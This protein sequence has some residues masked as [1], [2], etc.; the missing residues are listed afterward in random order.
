MPVS[1]GKHNTGYLNGQ[2]YDKSYIM[3]QD[4]MNGGKLSFVMGSAPN[5]NWASSPAS[6]P[7]SLERFK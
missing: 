1:H 2:P 3:H 7:Y 4:I 6:I 5:K